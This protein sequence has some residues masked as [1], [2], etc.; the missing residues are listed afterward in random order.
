V[1]GLRKHSFSWRAVARRFAAN[2]GTIPRFM[3]AVRALSSEG[4]GRI[5]YDSSIRRQLDGDTP[6]RRFFEGETETLPG[7][8][9][10]Q[11]RSDLGRLWESLPEGALSHDQNAYLRGHAA[12]PRSPTLAVPAAREAML[13]APVVGS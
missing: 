3:N 2:R 12:A 4:S 7:F 5:R 1:I 6:L 8:Y 11:V 10:D 9:T 13:A